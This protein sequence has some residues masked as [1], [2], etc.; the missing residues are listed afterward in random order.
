MEALA[1]DESD[2]RDCFV[3][4]MSDPWV[5]AIADALPDTVSRIQC[6]G[7]LAESMLFPPAPLRTLLLHRTRLTP[8]DGELL[9][10]L[11]GSRVPPPRVVLC[12][13][14]HIRYAEL[15]RWSALFDVLVPE[16]TARETVAR[17]FQ[18]R[19]DS[20]RVL[21]S[22]PRV[23]IVS[24]NFELR[25]ALSDACVAAGYQAVPFADWSDASPGGLAVWDVPLLDPSWPK[26]LSR[27]AKTSTVVA[28]FGFPDRAIVSEARSHGASAC[29]E[30][31]CDVDDLV[32]ILDRL[33][34]TRAE[35]AHDVPP[36]PASH[37]RPNRPVV[38]SSPEAYNSSRNSLG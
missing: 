25:H 1:L 29:L 8:H 28:L 38:V 3:G 20:P 27:R 34:A 6:E 12:A 33:A 17:Q 30:L 11:R 4:D 19:D 32:N 22:R 10:R 9:A 5:A 35:G 26:S 31:P 36:A 37:R 15:E 23:S 7:D 14:P 21:G 13:G 18:V 16:A 24:V 2:R